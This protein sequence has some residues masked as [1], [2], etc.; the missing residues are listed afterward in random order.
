MKPGIRVLACLILT[1]ALWPLQAGAASVPLPSPPTVEA[2]GYLLID[3]ASGQTL[4]EREATQRME[5]ASITKLMTAYIVF[6][7]LSDGRLKL[8]DEVT[9]SEH[10]WRAEGSRTFVKV[11]TRVPA[12]ILIKGM[13]IQ[14]GNDATI[15]LAEKLGGTEPAFAQMMNEYAQRLGMNDSH[16]EDATGLTPMPAHYSTARD[17][18]R[19]AQAIIREF[20]QYYGYYSQRE[21]TW[22]NIRQA[23]RNGLLTTDPSVDGIKTGHTEAAG[24]C[25]VSSAKRQ[26]TRLISVVLGTK[27]E[28]AREAASAALLNYGFTFYETVAVKKRGETIL[29]PRV[30]KGV[31]N[32][33]AVGP[34]TDV[35]VTVQRGQGAALTT[36]VTL[37][38]PLLAPLRT[39][40]AVGELQIR[41][42][43][44]ILQ[45]V[46]LYP[47]GDVPEAGFFGRMYD[48]ALLMFD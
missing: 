36:N 13:I 7:A 17:I 11:G 1:A 41:Q 4:A 35:A 38:R 42:G 48:A 25:L 29:K 21:F 19:L 8:T 18:A 39:T 26:G 2:R 24:Y 30:Y 33:V 27:N 16:F 22:N 5:P 12:E 6:H 3:A 20:P 31:V 40:T 44:Q 34:A 14:S 9:I 47:L 32:D 28:K 10:A 43:E 23:N 37:Q 46:P 45:R 15:A